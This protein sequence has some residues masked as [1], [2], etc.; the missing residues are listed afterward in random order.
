[1]KYFTENKYT[2][3]VI[4]LSVITAFLGNVLEPVAIYSLSWAILIYFMLEACFKLRKQGWKGYISHTGNRFDFLVVLFSVLFVIIPNMAVGSIVYLRLFR[5]LS[6]IKIVKLIPDAGHILSGLAR[7][8][9]ASKAIL[10][11]LAIQ[12][13]F[14][15][16][17]GFSLFGTYLPTYFGNPLSAMNTI[18]TIFTV[19]NWDTVPKAAE[20]LDEPYIYYAVNAF[21]IC[22][23]I[24]GGFISLSLA[25]AIFVDEMASDNNDE[26]MK[27]MDLLMAENTEIKKVLTHLEKRIGKP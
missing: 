2:S 8:M 27:K 20:A 10:T 21:V 5:V 3:S 23:L 6:L 11:L 22:V 9:K 14:F 4:I 26:I 13:V 19:E 12:L 16:L 18:F 24:L 15:S 17:L 25:N 7:A 1:M